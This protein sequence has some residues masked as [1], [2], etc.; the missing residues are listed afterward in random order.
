MYNMIL[1]VKKMKISNCNQ[2]FETIQKLTT[3]QLIKRLRSKKPSPPNEG[4]KNFRIINID[5]DPK[6]QVVEK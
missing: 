2:E 6:F 4:P 5:E 3:Y 1:E